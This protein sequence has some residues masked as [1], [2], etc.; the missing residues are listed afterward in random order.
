MFK[1]GNQFSK[2]LGSISL[3]NGS[4]ESNGTSRNNLNLRKNCIMF[5]FQFQTRICMY[6]QKQ[7]Q[8]VKISIMKSLLL[9]K[10]NCS[11]LNKIRCRC[12]SIY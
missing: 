11:Y 8:L 12:Q 7:K 3:D 2:F 4:Q 10:L 9:D 6:T 1:A 5:F